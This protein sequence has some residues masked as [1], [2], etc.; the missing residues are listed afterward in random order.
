MK[1]MM[2]NQKKIKDFCKCLPAR[3]KSWA[4][5]IKISAAK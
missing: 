2:K 5:T 3:G 4:T 1:K